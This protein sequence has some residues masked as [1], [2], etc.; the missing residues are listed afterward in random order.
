MLK[1]VI[2]PFDENSKNPFNVLVV[3]GVHG[4]ELTPNECINQLRWELINK[5]VLPPGLAKRS[6]IS[7][8]RFTLVQMASG[9]EAHAAH[10]RE[11]PKAPAR[12]RDI[13]RLMDGGGPEGAAELA[14]NLMALVREADVVIDVHSS[15]N[16]AELALVD[17][18]TPRVEAYNDWCGASFVP[19][20]FRAPRFVG[21]VKTR[22]I[23]LGKIGITVE[24]NGMNEVD[25]GSAK[26]GA[27]MII[28]LV[29]AVDAFRK[30]KKPTHRMATTAIIGASM[31]GPSDPL[32]S[33]LVNCPASGFLEDRQRASAAGTRSP[34]GA[35][36]E[37]GE[38]LCYVNDA[39]G[40]RLARVV[41]PCAGW[42]V[43]GPPH[44]FAGA[45][46]ELFMIQPEVITGG[47]SRRIWSAI[48]DYS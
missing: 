5:P 48:P 17:V 43:C 6:S 45:G 23:E 27:E 39:A 18:G 14:K 35:R 13:N 37:P 38:I 12:G 7:D 3:S 24:L 41:S 34:V 8:A 20:A 32:P 22:A 16:C 1:R 28:R 4:D 15:A 29:S 26:R 36:V 46:D 25:L 30:W 42:V 11:V 19:V 2:E 47:K 33:V 10:S 44:G 31:V 21:S 40:E 9:T